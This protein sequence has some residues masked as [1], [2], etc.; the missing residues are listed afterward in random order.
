MKRLLLLLAF[1]ARAAQA[2]APEQLAIGTEP[3]V[4]QAAMLAPPKQRR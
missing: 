3:V 4:D 2:I 1:L